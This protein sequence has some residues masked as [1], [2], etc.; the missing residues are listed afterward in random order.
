MK[1]ELSVFIDESGDFGEL[2][3]HSPYYIVTL[4]LHEQAIPITE[5]IKALDEH[6]AKLGFPHHA[7]HTGPLIRRE[8]IYENLNVDER[9]KLF[10][11][12][13]NFVRKAP[14]HYISVRVKKSECT[15]P[16]SFSG[17]LAKGVAD[18]IKNHLE[19]FHSFDEVIVY[20]DNGQIELSRILIAVFSA[21]VSNVSFRKVSPIDYKLFQAADLICTAELLD[22]KRKEN[23]LSKSERIFFGSARDYQK[24]YYKSIAKKQI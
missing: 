9:K 10:S 13:F 22:L 7:I 5:N 1:N 21:L 15:D 19:Y 16:V 18:A 6:I 24:N 3:T 14:I 17:K 4:V 2:C 12:L 20:Y 11:G 8:S 23:S